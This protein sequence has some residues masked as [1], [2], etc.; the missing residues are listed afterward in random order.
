[1]ENHAAFD[2]I[3]FH[4]CIQHS[5]ASNGR[6]LFWIF[7]TKTRTQTTYEGEMKS[8]QMKSFTWFRTEMMNRNPKPSEGNIEYI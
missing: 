4:F 3:L 7:R 6:L 2:F 8:S 1:M 5:K